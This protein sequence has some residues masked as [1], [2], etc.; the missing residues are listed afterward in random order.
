MRGQWAACAGSG[1]GRRVGTGNGCSVGHNGSGHSGGH[2][3]GQWAHWGACT[4][5]GGILSFD[6]AH[7]S[8]SPHRWTPATQEDCSFLK[9]VQSQ[10]ASI[11][12]LWGPS[13]IKHQAKED[14]GTHVPP[15][16]KCQGYCSRQ[17]ICV[18]KIHMLDSGPSV[19]VSGRGLREVRRS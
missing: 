2:V 17:H 13:P 18:P 12:G 8:V 9:L 4:A 15:L 14:R 1:R 3:C 11:H 16:K 5:R 19:V 6:T 7:T 10:S